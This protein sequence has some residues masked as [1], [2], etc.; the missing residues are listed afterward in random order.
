MGKRKRRRREMIAVM[1][2]LLLALISW[3]PDV[4]RGEEA[5][6]LAITAQEGRLS[7][8]LKDAEMPD[9]FAQI[10]KEAG[11]TIVFEA[12]SRKR[13][14]IQFRDMEFDQ[15]LRRL[16]GLAALDYV[17]V[18]AQE[19]GG[20]VGIREVRILNTAPGSAEHAAPRV[21]WPA[22]PVQSVSAP[23]AI[24]G[25]NEGTRRF[26]EALER[27]GRRVDGPAAPAQPG[28]GSPAVSADSEGTRRFREA[29]ER[30]SR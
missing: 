28:S 29:L 21:E 20:A 6:R 25:D 11:I 26:R 30:A 23:P 27:A 15:G 8:D 1:A 5:R 2:G 7:V 16:L 3:A 4:S 13:V 22:A 9:I 14:S 18:Y 19:P 10:G 12:A 24:S 17:I